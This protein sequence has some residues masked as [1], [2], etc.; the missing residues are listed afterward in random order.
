MKNDIKMRNGH[1]KVMNFLNFLKTNFSS[2]WK[3]VEQGEVRARFELQHLLLE[4]QAFDTATGSPPRGMQMDLSTNQKSSDTIV[5]AN[6]GYFQ[7]KANPGYWN[8]RLRPGPSNEIYKIEET[9]QTDGATS[10]GQNVKV[11]I[12][13][14]TSRSIRVG[15]AKKQG[16][17]K[18]DVLGPVLNFY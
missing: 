1:R 2:S 17:E 8:L 16:M 11:I 12:S 9:H 13:S 18:V 5:M 15:V 7:F 3:L 10:D 6:L 14:F 4:G